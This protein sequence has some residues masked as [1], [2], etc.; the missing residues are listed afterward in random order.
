MPTMLCF[1]Q[2][3]CHH[4][5]GR[6]V[7]AGRAALAGQPPVITVHTYERQ[8]GMDSSK[9]MYYGVVFKKTQLENTEGRGKNNP[10]FHLL[11]VSLL[12]LYLSIQQG[13][14]LGG[15]AEKERE[16]GAMSQ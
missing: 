10:F 2:P 5:D 7:P 16:S 15:V 8:K 11:S 6:L 12:F 13:W 14:E 9:K 3:L 1:K 4:S